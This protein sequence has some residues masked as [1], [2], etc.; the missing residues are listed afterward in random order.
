MVNN[1]LIEHKKLIEF[2]GIH[3]DVDGFEVKF[4][5]IVYSN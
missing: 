1:F 2:L 5:A 4:G 3:K